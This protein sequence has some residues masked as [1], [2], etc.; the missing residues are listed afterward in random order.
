MRA[1]LARALFLQPQILLLDEPTNHLDLDAVIWLQSYLSK[2]PKLT[3][4]VVSHDQAFLSDV[5][6]D[7][8]LLDSCKLH[9]FEVRHVRELSLAVGLVTD[10]LVRQARWSTLSSHRDN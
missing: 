8:L 6:T 3:L 9:S 5:C 1:S 10:K 7:I 2:S 4:V